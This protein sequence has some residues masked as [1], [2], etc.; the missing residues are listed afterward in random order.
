MW[1]RSNAERPIPQDCSIL[2]SVTRP[3]YR[4]GSRK[5]W[6]EKRHLL[7]APTPPPT[8]LLPRAK[9]SI[10]FSAHLFWTVYTLPS[11]PS[12]RSS[13]S[14]SYS[15]GRIWRWRWWANW[16]YINRRPVRRLVTRSA[17]FSNS[18]LSIPLP[19]S[20]RSLIYLP[21]VIRRH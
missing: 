11:P 10:H 15:R 19:C 8:G 3:R 1:M 9:H 18:A 21:L 6:G 13:T 20:K 17:V 4:V 12:W 7:L 14:T 5:S 16:G 2:H